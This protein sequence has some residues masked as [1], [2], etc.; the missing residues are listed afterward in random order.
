MTPWNTY[1]VPALPAGPISN[2]GKEA[3]HAALWPASSEFLFFVSHNDGTHEFTR[4]YGDHEKAV[5]KFQMD[6]E[7]RKGR[8]WRDLNKNTA[9]NGAS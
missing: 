3:I 7:A 2:P 8:S 1:A 9:P 5:R 4:N 6:P